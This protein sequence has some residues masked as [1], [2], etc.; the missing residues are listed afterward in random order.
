MDILPE[1]I[2]FEW[3]KGNIDKNFKKHLVTNQE[4]EEVF[5]NEPIF[6]FEDEKHSTSIEARSMI[7]GTT[8]SG[9]RL[10]IIYTVRNNIVRVISARDLNK[11]ERREYEYKTKTV[12]NI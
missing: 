6:L 7:W 4:A 8:K 10:T 12:T 1:P 9:R 5:S 2:L 3:D 11:K